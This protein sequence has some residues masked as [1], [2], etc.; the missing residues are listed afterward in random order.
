MDNTY[1]FDIQ[2]QVVLATD[3]KH[4]NDKTLAQATDYLVRCLQFRDLYKCAVV[5]FRKISRSQGP[6]I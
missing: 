5:T 1:L 3:N 4:K 6:G 2:S